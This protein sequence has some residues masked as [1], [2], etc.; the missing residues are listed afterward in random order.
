[1]ATQGRH[2]HRFLHDRPKWVIPLFCVMAGAVALAPSGLRF[3]GD[4]GTPSTH[5][6]E[7][8][9]PGPTATATS[10][11]VVTLTPNPSQ[12]VIV[13]SKEV[14]TTTTTVVALPTPKPSPSPGANDGVKATKTP[15]PVSSPRHSP[16]APGPATGDSVPPTAGTG[17]IS[18]MFDTVAVTVG[19]IV[20]GIT[21]GAVPFG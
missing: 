11:T 15:A 9:L 3:G 2:T 5:R 13:H 4:Q 17:P 8:V 12:R 21:G 1:M 6:A 19:R 14:K 18:G 10:T 7:T 16:K 20:A